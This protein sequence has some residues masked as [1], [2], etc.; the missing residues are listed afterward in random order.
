MS[1]TEQPLLTPRQIM[2]GKT[3]VAIEELTDEQGSDWFII[4][5]EDG[6]KVNILDTG[7]VW[8]YPNP[9]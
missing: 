8:V 9:I 6:F 3:I 7:K 2:V 1:T 4:H 5:L